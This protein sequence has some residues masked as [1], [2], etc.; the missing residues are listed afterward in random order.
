MTMNIIIKNELENLLNDIDNNVLMEKSEIVNRLKNV[1]DSIDKYNKK[2][3]P[4]PVTS[5]HVKCNYIINNELESKKLNDFLMEKKL[6]QE[7]LLN[8]H[9]KNLDRL[10]IFDDIKINSNENYFNDS[11][12]QK[13][14]NNNEEIYFSPIL[15]NF[16][17]VQMKKF[18]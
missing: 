1:I 12:L 4:L 15:S 14:N 3:K 11:E 5:D 2:S 16:N 9:E 7:K 10:P 13:N 6:Y 18:K 17:Y 8:T